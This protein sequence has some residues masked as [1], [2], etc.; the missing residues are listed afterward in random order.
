[1]KIFILLPVF[2]QFLLN[3]T[4]IFLDS[5][6]KFSLVLLKMTNYKVRLITKLLAWIF[7]FFLWK[8]HF[9]E[10]FLHLALKETVFLNLKMACY[11]SSQ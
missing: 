4:F 1:M 10:G 7:F 11:F 2:S 3:L 8:N 5:D 9:K 6:K